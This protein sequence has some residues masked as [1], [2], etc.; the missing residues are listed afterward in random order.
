MKI[1]GLWKIINRTDAYQALPRKVSNQVIWHVYHDRG[2]YYEVVKVWRVAPEKF[3]AR[4]RIPHYKPKQDGRTLVTYE[5]GAINHKNYQKNG[6]V[7]PSGLD[8]S[9]PVGE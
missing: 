1:E 8:L 6:T 5:K 4:P 7:S 3:K 2:S 9:I